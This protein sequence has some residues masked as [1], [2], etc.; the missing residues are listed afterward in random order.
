MITLTTMTTITT[1]TI[2]NLN[3]NS[4]T[5][6]TATTTT[7]IIITISQIIPFEFAIAFYL[8]HSSMHGDF[9]LFSRRCLLKNILLCLFYR[10]Y[11]KIVSL[12][13]LRDPQSTISQTRYLQ[14]IIFSS[15]MNIISIL[16]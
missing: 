13:L 5:T 14:E 16:D 8:H 6:T 11:T 10:I 9:T 7:A 15:V 1:T 4:S 12:H 2:N 3:N